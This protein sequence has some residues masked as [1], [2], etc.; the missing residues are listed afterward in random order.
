MPLVWRPVDLKLI[1]QA[2]RQNLSTI[3]VAQEQW[4]IAASTE[5]NYLEFAAKEKFQ[6]ETTVLNSGLR[7]HWLGP[8]AAEKNIIYFHGGMSASLATR[9]ASSLTI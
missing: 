7:L 2:L 5:A 1:R 3:N 4:T 6:P 9:W 8:K